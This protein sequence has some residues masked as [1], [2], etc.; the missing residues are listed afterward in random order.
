MDYNRNAEIMAEMRMKPE[1]REAKR[2]AKEKAERNTIDRLRVTRELT[3]NQY[4]RLLQHE[5]AHGELSVEEIAKKFN[6]VR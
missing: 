6:L 5:A 4:N 2:E 1:E 3:K